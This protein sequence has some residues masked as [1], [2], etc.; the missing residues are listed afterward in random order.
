MTDTT[1]T[2]Q[3][4]YKARYW[5]ARRALHAKHKAAVMHAMMQKSDR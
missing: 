5:S 4:D 3:P 1:R 2:F